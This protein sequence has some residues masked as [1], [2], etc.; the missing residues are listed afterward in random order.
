MENS[1]NDSN[2]KKNSKIIRM[3]KTND[4]QCYSS[5]LTAQTIPE[6]CP[7]ARCPPSFYT[8]VYMAYGMEQLFVQFGSDVSSQLLV[9]P[10]P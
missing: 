6:Q 5:P 9:P 1:N 4:A 8:G 7:L 2:N 10:A 3:Y